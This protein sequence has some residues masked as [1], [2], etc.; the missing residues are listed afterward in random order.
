MAQDSDLEKTEEATPKRIEKARGEGDVPRSKELATVSVLLVVLMGIWASGNQLTL[1]LKTNMASSLSLPRNLVFE[2]N[3][4]LVN[5]AH[6][7]GELLW[8]L[9]P[10]AGIVILVAV[11]APVL[12]GGWI[13]SGKA[14]MPKFSK[15]NPL[16]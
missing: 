4:L 14:F 6:N 15:L 2:P 11:A 16:T 8:A 3:L 7:L 12:L 5:I 13:F 9:L 1:A 10:L